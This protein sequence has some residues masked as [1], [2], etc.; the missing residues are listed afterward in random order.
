MALSASDQILLQQSLSQLAQ[1]ASSVAR[2]SSALNNAQQTSATSTVNLSRVQTTSIGDYEKLSK[3][4][5]SNT[6]AFK[7]T[8]KNIN[9]YS[10][11]IQQTTTDYKTASDNLD[12]FNR[13]ISAAGGIMTSAQR[14]QL[15][16]LNSILSSAAEDQSRASTAHNNALNII[17]DIVQSTR[18]AIQ[19]RNEYEKDFFGR[20]L[21]SEVRSSL[22]AIAGQVAGTFSK[23]LLTMTDVERVAQFANAQSEFI[24]SMISN[25]NALDDSNA[26]LGKRY[27]EMGNSLG[28]VSTE[29]DLLKSRIEGRTA[30]SSTQFAQDTIEKV[31]DAQVTIAE[32]INNSNEKLSTTI[33]RDYKSF[34]GQFNRYMHENR[35]GFDELLDELRDI[36]TRTGSLTSG[37][38]RDEA[39]QL[40]S[41]S[42]GK[43]GAIIVPK[44]A[45]I[46]L[47]VLKH[48][49]REYDSLTRDNV[50]TNR[51][52]AWQL[53][54]T[55]EEYRQSRGENK[56]FWN[57]SSAEGQNQ[58]DTFMNE[59]Y[60]QLRSVFGSDPMM[61]SKMGSRMQGLVNL[62]NTTESG[63][64]NL[65]DRFKV[66][67][68]VARMNNDELAEMHLNFAESN[69][70][71]A[72]M[73]S[74]NAKDR[75][76]R[77]EAITT[78]MELGASLGMTKDTL[79]EFM[80]A[81]LASTNK[82]MSAGETV[83]KIGQEQ[84]AFNYMR[85]IAS[86]S[87]LNISNYGLDDTQKMKK[88]LEL[89]RLQAAK[90]P[91]SPEEIKF[92]TDMDFQ[93]AKFKIDAQTKLNEIDRKYGSQAGYSLQQMISLLDSNLEQTKM[94]GPI[95]A[96]INSFT[97]LG[98][99]GITGEKL[100]DT[101][102]ELQKML[103]SQAESKTDKSAEEITLK[104]AQAQRGINATTG[105]GLYSD[106][107]TKAGITAAGIALFK[108]FAP[109]VIRTAL[110]D[111]IA[112]PLSK[113]T[114][115]GWIATAAAGLGVYAIDKFT[116]DDDEKKP[117]AAE[118]QKSTTTVEP[119]APLTGP[120]PS[121]QINKSEATDN[122]ADFNQ[123][124]TK[125]MTT[126][127]MQNSTMQDFLRNIST[128]STGTKKVIDD[129]YDL[130]Q[131]VNP[132]T[133]II[134]PNKVTDASTIK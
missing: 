34:T 121:G 99:Y 110:I 113:V 103:K 93:I 32:T 128:N 55:E 70:N 116:G 75:K 24:Q 7:D 114:P 112:N 5:K 27:V 73:A 88:Y 51:L 91:L 79:N 119:S 106:I 129:W 3:T 77:M 80:R 86:L 132:I 40:I 29:F 11:K 17:T 130:Y 105:E 126:V 89:E 53:R 49:T 44:L 26:E 111:V 61:I 65:L 48:Y 38:G 133:S 21:A 83:S 122:A 63:I 54:L 52:M 31:I 30:G 102:E 4:L 98:K 85:S 12:N 71:Q 15:A 131:Q 81:M 96:I 8:L 10:K 134:E 64:G 127:E 20:Q 46:G 92:K 37:T 123:M 104:A 39:G 25:N 13:M 19:Y 14:A 58:L 35:N 120:L 28:Y 117:E 97:A 6:D 72:V 118:A 76:T 95:D 23:Q 101:L 43:L 108:R 68:K 69:E 67:G 60:S 107:A 45:E 115:A 94:S 41:E 42:I 90:V 57:I 47:I 59:R 9:D 56:S 22:D 125:Y 36:R 62:S 82:M 100:P 66:L 50:A 84:T 33:E 124:F 87:G 74:L 109:T 2:Y 16:S 78:T 1:S 18:D